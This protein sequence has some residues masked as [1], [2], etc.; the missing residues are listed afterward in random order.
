MPLEQLFFFWKLAGGD[1]ENLIDKTAGL[2]Y[3]PPI[4][5][6]PRLYQTDSELNLTSPDT[7]FLFD[8]TIKSLP[9]EHVEQR[10]RMRQSRYVARRGFLTNSTPP[11]PTLL[12]PPFFSSGSLP[13]LVANFFLDEHEP[14]GVNF[15]DDAEELEPLQEEMD[16]NRRYL[17][18]FKN[19]P[20]VIREKNIDYQLARLEIFQK[21]LNEYPFSRD[22]L[23]R[24]AKVD[25]PP[26][27]RGHVWAAILGIKG[28]Y[29]GEYENCDK[30]TETPTDRQVR[31]RG[32]QNGSK[33]RTK[34]TKQK[35]TLVD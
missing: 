26:L 27:L 33:T 34:K 30:E 3:T 23:I 2:G 21:L 8:D 4:L 15:L 11:F 20:L 6:L 32:R 19:V 10:L 24:E 7:D 12:F 35:T 13:S 18:E 14:V 17:A 9:L 22:S 5:R 25:I 16:E 1:L 28:D 31:D 29:L